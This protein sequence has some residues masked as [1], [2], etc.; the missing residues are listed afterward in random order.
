MVDIGIGSDGPGPD[1]RMSEDENVSMNFGDLL[2]DEEDDDGE[3]DYS[4][5]SC[6]LASE[7]SDLQE[8]CWVD[9]KE[10]YKGSFRNVACGN[11]FTDLLLAKKLSSENLSLVGALRQNSFFL[12]PEFNPNINRQVKSSLF[13]FLE[14]K[15][16]V[17]YVPSKGTAMILM[18]TKHPTGEINAT[19]DK[20]EILESYDETKGGVKTFV[21][22]LHKHSCRQKTRRW[23]M[24]CF[25][26]LVDVSC[27]AAYVIWNTE[28]PDWNLGKS[29]H[30]ISFLMEVGDELVQPNIERE[31]QKL[32]PQL[33]EEMLLRDLKAVDAV[34]ISALQS[35]A[36]NLN[37]FAQLAP[38]PC[39][40]NTVM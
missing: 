10:S 8:D 22:R 15:T 13:G 20:P 31:S 37:K 38:C 34:A 21:R 35:Q 11:Y 30:R 24:V 3:S 28:H 29:D 40:S 4:D 26:N 23:P 18:S 36:A 27:F 25:Y 6:S 7:E 16:L 19:T 17:S 5:D 2:L 1:R 33:E 14:N 12:P 39:V 32:L 9:V